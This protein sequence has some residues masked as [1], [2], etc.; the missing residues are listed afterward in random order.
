MRN[1]DSLGTS[2][3]AV[4][5][6]AGACCLA[7]RRWSVGSVP[8]CPDASSLGLGSG[9]QEPGDVVLLS[10]AAPHGLCT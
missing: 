7:G 2:H 9:L 10:L 6:R 4:Q 8:A 3:S 1:P 5:S